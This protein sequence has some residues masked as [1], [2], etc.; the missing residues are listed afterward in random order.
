MNRKITPITLLSL[1]LVA[2]CAH[3]AGNFDVKTAGATGDGS[4]IDTAAV[5]KAIDAAATAGGG[6]VDFP[7][8]TYKIGSIVMK[9]HVTLNLAKGAEIKGSS[10]P[11]DYPVIHARWEGL[12]HE[13]YQALISADNAVDIAI[14]GSGSI[15]GSG[16]VG[17]L[18]APRGPVLFE[19]VDCK[20]VRVTGVTVGNDG[21][22]TMHPT[23]CDGVTISNMT[24]Y[25]T[26][27]NS[28]GFD[29][30]STTNVTVDHVTFTAG[31]DDISIKCG[32]GQE[33]VNMGKPSTDITV[34]D[35]T[36]LK[37]HGALAMGS[38][39]SGGIANVKMSRCYVEGTNEAI[40]FKTV[41][42][43][44]GYVKNLSVDHLQISG[45]PLLKI[46]T[47]Y[48]SNPD[49]QG[50]PGVAG[51]TEIDNISVSDVTGTSKDIVLVEG[52]PQ[53]PINGLSLTNIHCS[54]KN[55][56]V[57]TNAKGVALKNIQIDGV[58][59][60]VLSTQNVDGTGLDGAVPYVPK[61]GK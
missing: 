52:D 4:T 15:M 22:W 58:S 55:G 21:V 34:T 48:H 9:S 60:P 43:R 3:S 2:S 56:M 8:G 1:L 35:C 59:G 25:S 14:T 37:G 54:S 27:K 23:F 46:Q 30:D 51:I 11:A 32:K 19:P 36:F 7:A 45:I 61:K 16:S 18:R 40:I 6:E 17:N 42:G 12:D 33:G 29:P 39:L 57:I 26:G 10:K 50:V 28:D 31:D 41:A 47:T 13:C 5:Q 53:K 38:E 20:D 49:S 44:G 24:V